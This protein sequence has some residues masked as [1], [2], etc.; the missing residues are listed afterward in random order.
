MDNIHHFGT[1][2]AHGRILGGAKERSSPSESVFKELIICE[3]HISIFLMWII[4]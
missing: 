3:I 2:F 1:G 4:I